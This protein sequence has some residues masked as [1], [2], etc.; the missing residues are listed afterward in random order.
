MNFKSRNAKQIL[1]MSWHALVTTLLLSCGRLTVCPGLGKSPSGLSDA[2][3]SCLIPSGLMSFEVN[4][5][6]I[7]S[8]MLLKTEPIE[9]N[10][11]SCSADIEG[12]CLSS[13]ISCANIA[14]AD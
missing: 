7:C 9:E 1:E 13:V 4:W 3:L 5:E 8:P 2:L 11:T 14:I 10:C 12:K 6:G